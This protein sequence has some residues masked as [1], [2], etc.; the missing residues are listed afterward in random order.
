[1]LVLISNFDYLGNTQLFWMPEAKGFIHD[2]K[3]EKL[4]EDP[5]LSFYDIVDGI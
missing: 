4:Q 1:M 5:S 2:L 3:K